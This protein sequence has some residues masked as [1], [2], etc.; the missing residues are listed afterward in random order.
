MCLSNEYIRGGQSEPFKHLI[1]INVHQ[2]TG[3]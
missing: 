2:V 3:V 1:G